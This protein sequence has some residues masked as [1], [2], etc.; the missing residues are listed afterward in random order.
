MAKPKVFTKELILTAL[1][2]GSGVVSFGWNTGCLNSAQESIEPWIIESYHHRTG[3]TLSHY[4]LTF[5]W[6]TTIAIFAIGG[7]IG[8]FAASPV[9]RRYGRR[10][11]LLKA[12]LGIIAAAFMV[13]GIECGLYAGLC[14][15]YLSEVSPK[16]IRG[17]IGSLTG[18]C[19][20]SGLMVAEIVST[21]KMLGTDSRWPL[22]MVIAA[23]PS[24]TQ[25][26]L[27]QFCHE[28]PRFL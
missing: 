8:V 15:M 4:V 24:V 20:Y 2:T 18:L 27:L 1:A 10:G 7:A 11:D 14:T 25:F 21:P 23:L 6:S 13:L 12:K 3:I 28:I 17:M 22:I 5:I 9:S 19:A 26:M 16:S